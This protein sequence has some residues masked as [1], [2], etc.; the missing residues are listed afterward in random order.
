MSLTMVEGIREEGDAIISSIMMERYLSKEKESFINIRSNIPDLDKAVDGFRE[1]EVIVI[2]G[3]TKNG[4]TLLAQSLTKQF[5]K[6]NYHSL[7]FSFEV[8]TKQ[9]LSQFID[10]PLFYI[11]MIL[12]P[13]SMEWLEKMA[14]KSFKEY[15]TRVIFIDHL[16]YLFDLARTKNPSIEIGT[17][18]RR[19]KTLAVQNNFIVFLLCH[20]KKASGAGNNL[21]F[22]SIR[23]SS[24]VS[25]ES[26]CVL[27]IRRD[28]K[29][30]ENHQAVLKVEF[31]RRTGVLN[32]KILLQKLKGYLVQLSDQEV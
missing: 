1:G 19:L 10:L 12:K 28:M 14:K 15:Q 11:P 16:H 22:E 4:K 29:N 27:L 21:T 2:S 3:P 23:D 26:D 9:F 17:I 24:F 8:P 20:T 32:K 18:I 5:A 25:Q 6:Q 30:P 13:N 31:H 7:W